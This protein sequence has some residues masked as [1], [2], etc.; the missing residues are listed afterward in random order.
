VDIAVPAELV[1]GLEIVAL[2]AL[3]QGE[4]KVTEMGTVAGTPFI[5]TGTLKLLVP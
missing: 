1:T 4:V 5:S 2:L 3:T